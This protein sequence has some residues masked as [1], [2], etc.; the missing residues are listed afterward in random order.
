MKH[1]LTFGST[2][3]V[4]KF[5]RKILKIRCQ[6]GL[7]HFFVI[8]NIQLEDY[9]WMECVYIHHPT[10]HHLLNCSFKFQLTQQIWN[11]QNQ[12]KFVAES[13]S[14]HLLCCFMPT[15]FVCFGSSLVCFGSSLDPFS[16]SWGA[17]P[18]D[19]A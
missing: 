9:T 4:M 6:P 10:H 13:L 11:Q 17:S 8:A 19:S 16:Q 7:S 14:K 3:R 2:Q 12:F 18:D 5:D 15:V 1:F